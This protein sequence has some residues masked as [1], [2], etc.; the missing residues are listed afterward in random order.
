MHPGFVAVVL[1]LQVLGGT[2]A[3][4]VTSG[5]PPGDPPV[6]TV[7]YL[8]ASED[9]GI[10]LSVRFKSTD[11]GRR[12]HGRHEVVLFVHG[13]TLSSRPAFDPD[14]PDASWADWMA[15]RGYAVY[16]VDIRNYGGSTRERAMDEPPDRNP[17]PSRAHEAVRDIGAVVDHLRARHALP[18]VNLVGWSWGGTTAGFYASLHPEKVRRLVLYAPLYSGR[19]EAE[20]FTPS[21]AYGYVAATLAGLR[22]A[23]DASAPVPAGAPPR[24]EAVLE[25]VAAA[26]RASDP[27]SGSRSP[28][29]ARFPKGCF[30][31]L[32]LARIGRP[33]WSASSIT[34]DT[35]VIVGDRD[36]V[37][38]LDHAAALMRD[39]THARSPKLVVL[40]GSTHFAQFEAGRAKLFREVDAFLRGNGP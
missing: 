19:Q 17:A 26:I 18:Q 12:N 14:L 7:D 1:T 20:P 11:G 37:A 31:D 40:E 28:A 25:S 32:H 13:A 39:L 27:T 3:P 34:A 10:L 6:V 15:R 4:R 8:V 24:D 33:L 35:L 23:W 9:P 22:N 2:D 21:G 30:E 38:P 16:L 5:T 29:S 36:P